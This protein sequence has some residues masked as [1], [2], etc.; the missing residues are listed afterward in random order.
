MEELINRLKEI[1]NLSELENSSSINANDLIYAIVKS[2]RYELFNGA[3]I[4]LNISDSATLETLTD[5]LLSDEDILYYIH[6][7]FH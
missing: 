1:T 5:F 4:R 3:N 2:K 6:I 7:F